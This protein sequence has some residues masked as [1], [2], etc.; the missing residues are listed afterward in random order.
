MWKNGV[1][2]LVSSGQ[3]ANNSAFVDACANGNDAFFL[4]R[5]QLVGIDTD[6]SIDLYDA[7]VGGGLAS[8]NPPPPPPPCQG[9][10]CK[11]PAT[12]QSGPPPNGTSAV[13]NPVVPPPPDCSSLDQ[14]A[15]KKQAKV[16]KLTKRRSAK[17]SGKQKKKLKKKLKKAKKQAKSAQQA[18]DAVQPGL[19]S[20]TKTKTTARPE[21]ITTEAT[22]RKRLSQA[23]DGSRACCASRW[24]RMFVAPSFASADLLKDFTAEVRDQNGNPYTQAGGHPF[25]AF[26]DI[27]FNTHDANGDLDGPRRERAHGQRRPARGP[28]RQPP[29]HPP[30]A[31]ARSS[32]AAFGGGCPANTQVGV[33]VLKT[34]LG[35]DFV[36][37]V[38]NMQPPHGR[39]G[40]VRLHRPDPARLHQRLGA[41]RRRPFGDDPQHLPGAAADRHQPHLLGRARRPRPRRRPRRPVCHNPDQT[42]LCPFQ[43][44]VAALPYQPDLLLGPR[45]HGP[46]RELVAETAPS[47]PSISTTPV[48]ADGCAAVPFEPTVNVQSGTPEL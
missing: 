48:G 6:D 44:P 24:R 11:P 31:P 40:A 29:E 3:S 28:G 47:R 22:M 14:K 5:E 8:Q 4:T 38:Y 13:D 10:A 21:T 36:S 17:A 18:A 20:M 9:D 34:G 7:R 35:Q 26:T 16:D 43:G 19:I 12:P 23:D 30:C 15:E 33:T 45:R 46:A 42:V 25:E 2:E 39:A 32:P 37:A 1:R 27:N 41:Q